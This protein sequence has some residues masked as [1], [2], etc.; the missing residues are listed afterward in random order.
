M[1]VVA[2]QLPV[3]DLTDHLAE[4]PGALEQRF[5]PKP[6]GDRTLTLVATRVGDRHIGI[7]AEP[8]T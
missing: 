7:L 4:R 5:L 3:I 2:T 6:L 1:A 8:L